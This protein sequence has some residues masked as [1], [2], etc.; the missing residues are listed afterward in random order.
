[1]ECGQ[2][3]QFSQ[4]FI[5]ERQKLEKLYLSYMHPVGSELKISPFIPYFMGEE[6]QFERSLLV[7]S[8]PF[9]KVKLLKIEP[10]IVLAFL[11]VTVKYGSYCCSSVQTLPFSIMACL[12]KSWLS[13]TFISIG[14]QPFHSKYCCPNK[15]TEKLRC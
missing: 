1:M 9:F 12:Y 7:V 4:R 8:E 5:K 11:Q 13:R 14:Q 3:E 15:C 2:R 6:V 10:N